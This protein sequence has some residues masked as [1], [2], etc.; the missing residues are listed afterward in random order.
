MMHFL[1][2][3]RFACASTIQLK[4]SLIRRGPLVLGAKCMLSNSSAKRR[5][6]KLWFEKVR[7]RTK[8]ATR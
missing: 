4:V 7:E 6:E 1:A 3:P 8:Q 2:L 5:G